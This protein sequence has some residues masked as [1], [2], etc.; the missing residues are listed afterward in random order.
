MT[1]RKEL[2]RSSNEKKHQDRINTSI[3]DN[4]TSFNDEQQQYAQVQFSTTSLDNSVS[5]NSVSSNDKKH[6]DR[7][8]TACYKAET[9]RGG[10]IQQTYSSLYF[11]IKS[12]YKNTCSYKFN[13]QSDPSLYVHNVVGTGSYTTSTT[14]MYN[15]DNVPVV[16]SI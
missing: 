13:S 2:N 14:N 3:V 8:N 6:Q 15:K 9:L 11:H 5:S 4:S 10:S 16:W 12:K 7:I 1:V